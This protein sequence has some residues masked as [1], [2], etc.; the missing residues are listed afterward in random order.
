MR[1]VILRRVTARTLSLH[2]QHATGAKYIGIV[3]PASS[4]DTNL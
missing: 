3:W 1:A 4:G 2:D